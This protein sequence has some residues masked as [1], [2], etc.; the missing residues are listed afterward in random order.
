MIKLYSKHKVNDK[1]FIVYSIKGKKIILKGKVIS[2]SF[3]LSKSEYD[4]FCNCAVT[5]NKEL[6]IIRVNELN[7]FTTKENALDF[8]K[9]VENEF[10][11]NNKCA[12][13]RYSAKLENVDNYMLCELPY[14]MNYDIQ[15]KGRAAK[16]IGYEGRETCINV[17]IRTDKIEII[18]LEDLLNV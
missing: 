5:H 4:S 2:I 18:K 3:S 1:V 7:I 14:S 9:N 16:V 15:Y 11:S 10:I 17:I 8:I 12:N 6:K 13:K